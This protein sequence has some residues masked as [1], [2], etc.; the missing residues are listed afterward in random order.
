M[1]LS[2]RFRRFFAVVFAGISGLLF[3]Y[4]L[5]VITVALGLIEDD[6]TLRTFQKETVRQPVGYIKQ[7]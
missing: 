7:T 3:G 5:C 1:C 6:F 2:P 4:D